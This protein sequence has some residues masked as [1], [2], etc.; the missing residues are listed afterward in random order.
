MVDLVTQVIEL[1]DDWIRLAA[2]DAGVL[3]KILPSTI[4]VLCYGASA[5]DPNAAHVALS[6]P[7]VPRAFVIR[8]AVATPSLAFPARPT[9]RAEC[10]EWLNDHAP[11]AQPLV[12]R[13]RYVVV[14]SGQSK[15]IA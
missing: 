11:A 12:E 2:I 15:P 6:V 3:A 5:V 10:F 14:S 4:L 7:E 1:K 9:T 13:C 8:H